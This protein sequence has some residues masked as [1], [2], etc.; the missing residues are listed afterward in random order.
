MGKVIIQKYTTET[1]ISMI[2]EEAGICWNADTTDQIKNYRRGLDC[3]SSGHM[4]TAEYPQVYMILEGYSARV[5]R[6]FYTHI[7]GGPT[8]L[9]ASTR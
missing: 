8:R 1:P 4:R 3:L 7:A 9:Q 2:G 6:E 5:I